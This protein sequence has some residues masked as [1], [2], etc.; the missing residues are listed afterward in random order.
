ML[1]IL[2]GI[3]LGITL[4][5]G[6]IIPLNKNTFLDTKTD[7]IHEIQTDFILIVLDERGIGRYYYVDSY[8]AGNTVIWSDIITGGKP[9]RHTTPSGI[10]R[11]YHKKR[12]WM[13]TKFPDP[14]GINNMD[15]S[16]FF[17]GGIALHQGN[18]R[19]LSHGCIHVKKQHIRILFKYA[20]KNTPVIITRETYIPFLT[21]SEKRYVF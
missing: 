12:Y 2:L 14:S 18:T 9:P 8:E 5:F 6:K 17:N 13:S 20:H 10:F 1:K 3:L 15:Y 7:R 16:M 11:I 21:E 4:S 19:A